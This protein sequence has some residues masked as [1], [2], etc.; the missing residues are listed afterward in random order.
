MPQLVKGGKHVYAWVTIREDGTIT[1]PPEAIKDYGL[2]PDE[3]VVLLPGSITS[4][5]LS[6]ALLRNLS[7]SPLNPLGTQPVS[8]DVIHSTGKKP[9]TLTR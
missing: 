8:E 4:G 1:V 2:K 5:G 7:E 3:K 9:F 6:V